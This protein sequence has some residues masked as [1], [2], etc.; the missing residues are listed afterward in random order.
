MESQKNSGIQLFETRWFKKLLNYY[1]VHGE[2]YQWTGYEELSQLYRINQM[3]SSSPWGEIVDRMSLTKYPFQVHVRLPWQIQNSTAY[4]ETLCQEEV[5]EIVLKNPGPYNIYWSGGIDSTLVL[6]SFMKSVSASLIK[7]YGNSGS[8][9]ENTWF[10]EK[11]IRPNVEFFDSVTV[12]PSE[13]VIISGDCGDTIWAVLESEHIFGSKISEYIY[14]PWIEWFH[15]CDTNENFLEF[16]NTFM[17]RA[18]R[19]IN[20]LLEARWWFYMIC[21]SQSKAVLKLWLPT[22]SK[23]INF[24]E[25]QRLES[26]A[27]RNLDNIIKGKDWKSYKW[28]AKN[29]IYNFDHNKDYQKNK[30]K[31]YSNQLH[32]IMQARSIGLKDPLFITNI[33][34]GPV[35]KSVPFWSEKVYQQQYKNQYDHLFVPTIP[36]GV[37]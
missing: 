23:I 10:Y 7:V 25:S 17:S 36:R 18:G 4:L 19:P 29:I 6:V 13:G 27:W 35:I 3:F 11:Y 2:M 9:Q 26:W 21:K 12:T 22:K 32:K 24:Y 15:H 14:K 30:T 5:N 1:G 34:D 20:T 31:E 28:P 37:V 8:I 33:N 16:A